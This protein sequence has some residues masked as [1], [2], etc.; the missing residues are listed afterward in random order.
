MRDQ[1]VEGLRGIGESAGVG[2]DVG[3]GVGGVGVGVAV[4]VGDGGLV[5]IGEAQDMELDEGMY[6]AHGAHEL[7]GVGGGEP[8]DHV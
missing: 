5:G 2:V 1:L 6:T 7:A 8:K 4:G 3:L